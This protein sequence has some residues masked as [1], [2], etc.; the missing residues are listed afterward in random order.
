VKQS[1]WNGISTDP[2][3]KKSKRVIP[4]FS[5]WPLGLPPYDPAKGIQS[6]GPIFP[7]ATGKAVD[8]NNVLNRVIPPMLSVCR[9]CSKPK[10]E[11][12]ARTDHDYQ[13]ST[14]LPEWH[15]WHAFRRGAATNLN[16]LGGDD[17]T[18]AESSA[19]KM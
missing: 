3:S 10:K 16:R 1:I 4:S 14:V 8:P 19:M 11:H 17:Y 2:K 5:I 13:R 15:G 18:I 12:C 6:R 9:V 7:N